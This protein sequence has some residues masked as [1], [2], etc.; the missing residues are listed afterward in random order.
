M[1][2]P[3]QKK[4]M[5][6]DNWMAVN[7]WL[8]I[9]VVPYDATTLGPSC[10]DVIASAVRRSEDAE[11]AEL[12][13]ELAGSVPRP[14]VL[15]I[16]AYSRRRVWEYTNENATPPRCSPR[17]WRDNSLSELWAKRDHVLRVWW[18]LPQ[19][20]AVES[21]SCTTLGAYNGGTPDRSRHGLWCYARFDTRNGDVCNDYFVVPLR[22]DEEPQ[23]RLELLA[24]PLQSVP[25]AFAS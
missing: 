8:S 6:F 12:E 19:S 21:A 3:P 4:M 22:W 1:R 24:R 5:A 9:N 14:I 25:L 7:N 17:L 15:I 16:Q 18:N 20:G 10:V 2:W 23:F 13:R 11:R